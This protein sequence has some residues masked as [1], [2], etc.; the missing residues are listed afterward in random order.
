MRDVYAEIPDHEHTCKE[1]VR[2]ASKGKKPGN[3]CCAI[4]GPED[5][6]PER[7]ACKMYWDAVEYD[8]KIAEDRKR[9]ELERLERVEAN[10]NNPPRPAKWEQ[11]FDFGSEKL[12]NPYPCCPNCAEPLYELD[13]CYYCGQAIEEDDRMREWKKPP[14]IVWL[15]CIPKKFGGCGGKGTM[16]CVVSK[17]N[18]HKHGTCTVCGARFME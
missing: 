12:T 16:K 7:K 17:Y 3:R 2:W 15:D 10:R 8:R 9:E 18:G 1:C 5:I 14:E 6:T 4:D 11:D 13:R